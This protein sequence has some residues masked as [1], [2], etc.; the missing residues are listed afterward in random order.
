MSSFIIHHQ[1]KICRITK[2]AAYPMLL[3]QTHRPMNVEKMKK[4]FILLDRMCENLSLYRLECNM[5][6]DAVT[7]AYNGM[8]M[9]ESK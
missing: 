8:N 7:T 6:P 5:N 2:S 3:Q 4:I 1:N 9:E